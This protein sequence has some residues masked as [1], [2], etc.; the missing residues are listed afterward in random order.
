MRIAVAG[1]GAIGGYLAAE[2][3]ASGAPVTLLHRPG[4][5]P[6][7]PLVA[8]RSDG[9][10]FNASRSLSLADDPGALSDAWA[11]L[12]AVKSGD[13]AA[14]AGALAAALPPESPV[15]AFQN[16]LRHVDVLRER[17]GARVT[18]GVVTYNVSTDEEGRRRQ[19][20]R[21][22]LIA[23]ALPGPPG[24][25]LR[26]LQATFRSAGERLSLTGDIEGA[27]LGKLLVNLNNGV[28]AATGLGIAAALSDRDAR[29]C[30]VHCLREGLFWMG[31]A[32]LRPG[33]V[34]AVPPSL[35]PAVF[36]LPDALVRP[37][38][39]LIAGVQPGARFSTL[40]DLDRG[41]ATEIDDLNGEIV[42]LAESRWGS[43]PMNDLVT[44]TVHAHE[45]AAAS[46]R[47]PDFVPPRELR[48]RMEALLG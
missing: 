34:T 4:R 25:R 29:A 9:V 46:G 44:R 3:S 45:R 11:C 18:P 30:Y 17:L 39:R 42:R 37:L 28:C 10:V 16:G 19:A 47:R 5:P 22:K 24:E 41:R 14:L 31:R 13:T 23:G 38:A 15:I 40:Q 43:A 6:A 35:L 1:A 26:L 33:P 7:V 32:G 48:R 36:S 2:L 8:V 12:V 20:T 27:V 21:G